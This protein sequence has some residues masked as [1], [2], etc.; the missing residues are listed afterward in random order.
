MKAFDRHPFAKVSSGVT[1]SDVERSAVHV[2]TIT[3][4]AKFTFAV[5]F[6]LTG[7]RTIDPVLRGHCVAS[8]RP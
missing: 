8:C 2:I 7:P 4:T 5:N 1:A 6:P 3:T